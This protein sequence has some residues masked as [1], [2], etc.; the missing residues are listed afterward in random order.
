EGLPG[1]HMQIAIAQELE[2]VPEFRKQAGFNAYQE[3]WGLYAEA[4]AKE[5]PGTYTDPYSE[6]GRLTSEMWR[7]IRPVVDTGMH[8]KGWTQEQ[9]VEYFSEN[10]SI[11]LAT[12]QAEVQRY[13]TWPGQATSYKIGMI[14]IQ[15][16]RAKAEKEL[17]DGFDIRGFHDTV[18]G[19]GALPLTLLE[20]KIDQWI[21]DEKKA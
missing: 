6:Y 2:G 8:A 19:G 13:L 3:G 17:G 20:R 12:I 4:L 18:L 16:L 11:P 21:E 9:A 14:K 7:A 1:H 10:S 5:M 15:E